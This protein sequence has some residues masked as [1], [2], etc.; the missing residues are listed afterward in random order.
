[1]LKLSDNRQLRAA[2][3][4]GFTVEEAAQ[5]LGLD[6]QAAKLALASGSK[7]ESLH[8]FVEKLKPEM[9]NV[10]AEVARYGENEN[11]RVRAAQ[12]LLTGEGVIPEVSSSALTKRLENMKKAQMNMI[13]DQ[14]VI[15]L[16]PS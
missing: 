6:P 9:I 2:V 15:E 14:R 1:M 8:E 10:L 5:S 16:V 12:I 11:A 4:A 3:D 7:V 13:E